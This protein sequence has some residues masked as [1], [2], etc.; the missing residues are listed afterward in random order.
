LSQ[1][2]LTVEEV[3]KRLRCD[4]TTIYKLLREK[5][6]TH[7]RGLSRNIIMAEEAVEAYLESIAV[8]AE[9]PGQGEK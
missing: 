2:Y 4:E 8:Q 5:K 9:Q 1:N 3:A 7:I 6:I